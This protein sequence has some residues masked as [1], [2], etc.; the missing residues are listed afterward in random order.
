VPDLSKY[1][2]EVIQEQSKAHNSSV[3][4]LTTYRV[5]R[6][7]ALVTSAV[8]PVLV[9]L[10]AEKVWT[11]LAAASA[12]VALG[13]IQLTSL[14]ELSLLDRDRADRL[15][16]ALRCFE[17]GTGLY[18]EPSDKDQHQSFVEEVEE[19]RSDWERRR[20]TLVRRSFLQ[21]LG[22]TPEPSPVDRCKPDS[23]S[24]PK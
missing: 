19:I 21:H 9:L 20:E 13:L 17:T 14:D 6:T 15:H 18:A 10:D 24:E 5:L 4:L 22:K 8:T 12:A 7:V 1:V 16:R 23:E 3:W 11:T 2:D